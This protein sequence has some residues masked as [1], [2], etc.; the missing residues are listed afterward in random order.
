M[1]RGKT[2]AQAKPKSKGGR[3]KKDIFPAIALRAYAGGMTDEQVAH[4]VGCSADTLQR[5][6]AEDEEFCGAVKR[7]KAE[8]DLEVVMSLHKAAKGYTRTEVYTVPVG[9]KLLSRKVLRY[10]PPNVTACAIWLN[11]RQPEQ[12]RPVNKVEITG[13]GGKPLIPSRDPLAQLSEIL[14]D[15]GIGI[16]HQEDLTHKKNGSNGAGH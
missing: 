12:W 1:P 3:P 2:P 16:T 15:A 8:A 7:A 6:M 14:A 11:N 10:Y 13:K 4:L 5:R 9:G